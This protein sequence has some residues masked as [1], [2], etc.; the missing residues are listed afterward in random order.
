MDLGYIS[1]FSQRCHLSY[2]VHDSEVQHNMCKNEVGKSSFW[3]DLFELTLVGWIDL[4]A[5]ASFLKIKKS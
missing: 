1:L 2:E 5:E 4:E 3:A